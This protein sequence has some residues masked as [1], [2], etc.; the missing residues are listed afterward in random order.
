MAF[1]I[2]ASKR[3]KTEGENLNGS[4]TAW[5]CGRAGLSLGEREEE[6]S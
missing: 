5:G 1:H 2:L 3:A 6:L 4:E